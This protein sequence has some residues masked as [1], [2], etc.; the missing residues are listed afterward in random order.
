MVDVIKHLSTQ[1]LEAGID[2]LLA[3]PKDNG[4]L[5]MI[6]CRPEESQRKVLQEGKLDIEEG[7][8]GDNW[9]TRGSRRTPDGSAHPEMQLNIMNSRVTHLVATQ[10]DRWPLA[11]DQLY[12]DMDLSK[13]NLPPGTQLQLGTAVIEVTKIPHTGCEKFIA[14]FGLDAMKFVNGKFG[15]QQNFRGINAKVIKP[16]IIRTG[17]IFR[18]LSK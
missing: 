10:E 9:K 12:V 15:K 14:R 16:G 17:D 11:G 7:L 1:E 6:V 4:E 13:E 18:K 2:H 5:K 3:A 8:V